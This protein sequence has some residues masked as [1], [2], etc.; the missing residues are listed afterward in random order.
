MGFGYLLLGYFF[1]IELTLSSGIDIFPDLWGD[2]LLFT[3]LL[4]LG[5]YEP[6]F[7]KAKLPLLFHLSLSAILLGLQVM[8]S[9]FSSS[10]LATLITVMAVL[11]EGINLYFHFYLFL[12]I[13]DVC[14]RAKYPKG[15]Q[16]AARNLRIGCIYFPLSLIYRAGLPILGRYTVYFSMVMPLFS[17]LWVFLNLLLL[18]SCYRELCPTPTAAP[19]SLKH[20]KKTHN[21]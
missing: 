6:P 10:A 3:G 8:G 1:Q 16:R 17:L 13:R 21:H 5:G 11:A 15:E 9:V 20:Q 12:G 18:F 7:R 2:L 19:A 4:Y 14:H